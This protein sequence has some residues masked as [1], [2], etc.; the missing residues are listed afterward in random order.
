MGHGAWAARSHL[1]ALWHGLAMTCH[2]CLAWRRGP[3]CMGIWAVG[4]LQGL[5]Y[6]PYIVD[7][8]AVLDKNVGSCSARADRR[9]DP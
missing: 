4:S 9:A 2:A 1:S 5:A 6:Q 3:M 8:A 7:E